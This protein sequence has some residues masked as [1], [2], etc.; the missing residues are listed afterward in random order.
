E[1]FRSRLC[2]L[3][4]RPLPHLHFAREDGDG[5]VRAEVETLPEADGSFG[6]PGAL[7]ERG[8]HGHGKDQAGA[9]HLHKLAPADF[10]MVIRA[11][12]QFVAFRLGEFERGGGRFHTF[13]LEACA[14]RS[15]ALRMFT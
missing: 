13:S 6:A 5:S 12:A 7:G 11:F 15:T 4:A 10:K 3:R 9:E 8:R 2:E 1:F 14:A